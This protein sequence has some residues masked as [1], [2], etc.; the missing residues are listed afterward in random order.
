MPLTLT[1]IK[2]ARATDRPIKLFDGGGLYLLVKPE[3]SKLWRMKYRFNGVEKLLSIGTLD[4]YTLDDAR[5]HRHAARK[6]LKAGIDPSAKKQA[7]RGAATDTFRAIADEWLKRQQTLAPDTIEQFRTRL[8]THLY[9]DLGDVPVR[10]VNAPKLL[11]ALRR[12][13]AKGLH[14]TAHRARALAG[15][16][17]RY[18]VAT[19]RAERDPS[20]DLKGALT[21]VRGKHHAAITDPKRVGDLL[22]ALDGYSGQ[23]ATYC[24]LRLAPLVFVRPGELRAAEW[25]EIDLDAA[26]WRIPA[27][28]M[29]MKKAHL[30]PLSRQAVAILREMHMVSGEARYVFPSLLDDERPMSNNTVNMALRRLGYGNEEMTGHGFRTV[31]STLLNEKGF[32]P[33]V[34]ER[35]LAHVEQ[36][37]VRA[38]YN[39]AERLTERKAMMQAW[40]DYLDELKRDAEARAKAAQS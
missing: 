34:I 21:P 4:D 32:D 12:V 2:K 6:L 26:E 37:K 30:V 31:A 15:R 40:A 7:E 28:R 16:V 3:G 23:A 17:M 36:N 9:P 33:D 24:A 39:R 14:E 20:A 22:R 1:T 35:Q 19:G 11:D 10:E 27:S 25:S 5:E 18:A 29:K 38:A 13:E 8:E